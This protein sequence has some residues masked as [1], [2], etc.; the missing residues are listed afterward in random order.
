MR[1]LLDLD[2]AQL[3]RIDQAIAI[4]ASQPSAERARKVYLLRAL[5]NER[6]DLLRSNPAMRR[7]PPAASTR[8]V[9]TAREAE[10]L[11]EAE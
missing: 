9:V 1:S 10:D 11:V 2:K 5:E 4:F 6:R 3:D 7:R 8:T